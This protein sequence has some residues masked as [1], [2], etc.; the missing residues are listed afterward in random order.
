MNWSKVGIK[1]LL[2]IVTF[3]VAYIAANPSMV[4]QLI[5]KNIAEVTVGS[6]VAGALVSLAN[7]LKHKNDP[8]K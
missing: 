5:P 6:L 4:T 3:I 7:W 1:G 2:G 8:Q